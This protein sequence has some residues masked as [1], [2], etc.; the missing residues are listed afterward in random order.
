LSLAGPAQARFRRAE[1]A[2]APLASVPDKARGPIILAVSLT[3]QRLTVWENGV[4]V[5]RSMVSTG[6]AGH[7]TPRGAFTLLQKKRMH[8]SNIY[9][10]APMPFMQRITWSGV[11]LHQGHVTG[12]PATH[13]C[14]RL[15]AEV[16]KKLFGYTKIGAR[17]IITD[18]PVTPAD[19]AHPG[20]FQALPPDALPAPP[21]PVAQTPLETDAPTFGIVAT[22]PPAT[23]QLASLPIGEAA[24]PPMPLPE[25]EP[26]PP[27]AEAPKRQ[28]TGHVS[29]F[30]SGKERKLFIRQ[31]F[32]PVYE[33]PV[34]ISPGAA[35]GAHLFTAMEVNQKE[36][37]ASASAAEAL[38]RIQIPQEARMEVGRRL[39]AGASLLIADQ[40]LGRE[41]GKT[42]TDFILLTP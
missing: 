16:A 33:S 30:I 36:G 4:I 1:T 23:I 10:N 18:E 14:I 39:S 41:T 24:M 3:D 22:D 7:E 31:G 11:A 27:Q 13:G 9:S 6:V 2:A 35:L 28:P 17:V 5:A 38:E 21:A 32:E 15:P 19:F 20:L 26:A 40:G 25:P 37:A 8:R 12:R 42:A 34:E 29:V